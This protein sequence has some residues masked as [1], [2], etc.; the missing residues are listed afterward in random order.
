MT[1][2]LATR[3]TDLLDDAKR[4][5]DEAVPADSIY[6]LLHRERDRLFPDEMF[7]DLFHKRGRRSI[8]P[9]IV[10]TVMVLQRLEGCSDREAVDRIRFDLRWKYAAGVDETYPGFVH[11]VLVDM[12]ARL[13]D[14]ED[15][16]R[17]FSVTTDVARKAGLVG[18]RRVLDSAPLYDAVA[19]QDTVT[20]IR[21]A[22]RG[23]L[24]A[25]DEDLE[26]ELLA[27]LQRDDD[28][29]AAGKPVCDW[30]DPEARAAL[31]DELCNDALDALEALEGKALSP[32][33]TEAAELL[34]VVVGQDVEHGPDDLFRIARRTAKDRVISTVDTDARHGH[35]TSSQGFDGYK[36]HIA[37][38]PDSEIITAAAVGAANQG[39]GDMLAGLVQDV[40][41]EAADADGAGAD[42]PQEDRRPA[43]GDDA[44]H[45][46]HDP[47]ATSALASDDES[48]APAVHD[49]GARDDG[50]EALGAADAG[51]SDDESAASEPDDKGARDSDSTGA[52]D[53]SA[54]QPSAAVVYGD[55]AYGSGA[56]LAFLE[57]AGVVAMT[58]VQPPSAPG[59][60]FAKDR[61][62]IDL[63]AATVTCPN[64]VITP[65]VTTPSGNAYARFGDSCD[66]CP[67]RDQCTASATGRAV[68]IGP[69]EALLAKARERQ[70]DEAWKKDYRATR[71][72]VERKL[73]HLLR[74]RHGGRRARVRGQP[75]VDQDWKLLAAAVNLARLA[76][77]GVSLAGGTAAGCGR[78]SL[79][80]ARQRALLRRVRSRSHGLL[81]AISPTLGQSGAI[82]V[83]IAYLA[84]AT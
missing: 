21:S 10:A 38:D 62:V 49:E 47:C 46:A 7:E 12:R 81:A 16:D 44:S 50:N 74:R 57:D 5:C 84:P 35:K 32:E 80:L 29:A 67:L 33:V 17:V 71:P 63:D 39:D 75:R 23:L 83:R 30:D 65:I 53:Q 25:A 26:G 82:I 11:T 42:D 45:D 76:A 31:V 78:G 58:K 36:G 1:L 28:Y 18:V 56:N 41:P 14:S 66:S 72:K 3:Q 59:G 69:Y 34:A 9:S 4:F 6:A 70:Q 22:I 64:D 73:A 43:A 37:I 77:L 24:K 20:L 55:A 48:A 2:G 60:R 40:I 54:E 8:P 68:T 15:P 19:T 51:A 61:F 52:G 79:V 13:R 27:V